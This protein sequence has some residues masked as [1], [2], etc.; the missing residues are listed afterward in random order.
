MIIKRKNMLIAVVGVLGSLAVGYA[1]YVYYAEY[2]S[3][4]LWHRRYGSSVEVGRYALT[5]PT[6]WW[7]RMTESDGTIVLRNSLSGF[8][9]SS[10]TIRISP[11]QPEETYDSDSELL[12]A[13]KKIISLSEMEGN[14]TLLRKP[15]EIVVIDSQATRFYCVRELLY[16]NEFALHCDAARMQYHVKCTGL[17]KWEKE[18]RS[19]L[20]SWK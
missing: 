4:I 1:L 17:E 2:V 11:T 7:V 3:S 12:T 13:E 6:N 15:R 19:V 9:S 18:T 16:D 14:S 8:S 10:A 20:S 5:L